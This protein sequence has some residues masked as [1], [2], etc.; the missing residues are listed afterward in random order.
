[1]TDDVIDIVRKLAKTDYYQSMYSC[2]KELN[3]HIF[4][5]TTDL[6]Q[7]QLWLLSY[8]GMYST[9]NL[10]IAMGEIN[11]RVLENDVYEDAY[12]MYKKKQFSK[13]LKKNLPITKGVSEQGS[14]QSQWSFK[15]RKQV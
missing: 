1:M 5:N 12:L 11:E 4:V 2:A 13:D 9:I 7:L 14:P 3:M 15:K 10:D 8:M 6:T